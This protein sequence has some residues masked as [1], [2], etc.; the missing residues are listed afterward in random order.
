MRHSRFFF[1]FLLFGGAVFGSCKKEVETQIEIKEVEKQSSWAEVPSLFGL[2]RVIMSSGTDGQNLYLQQPGLFSQFTGRSQRNGLTTTAGRYPADV[3][4]R[5]PIGPS[6]FAYPDTD[7]SLVIAR[8]REQLNNL[9]Y[10]NLRQFDPA[11]T[12]FNTQV[13]SLSKCMAITP[14]NYLLA[15]YD[16]KRADRAFTFVLAAVAPGA[17][18]GPAPVVTTRQVTIP[19]INSSGAYVRNLEAID[20]YFLVNLASNGIY[21][22]KADGTFRQVY[23]PAA[24][25]A[26]YKWGNTVYAP[27]EYNEILTSTDNGEN[28]LKSTGTPLDFTLA[29]YYPVH[30]SLVGVYGSKLYTLRWNGP[31]YTLRTLKNDGLERATI[32]GIEYLRGTVYVA[33]T[34]GLFA[35]PV[36]SFFE[37]KP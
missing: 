26:F 27:I 24:V 4:V 31:R 37:T 25:D 9:F 11:A 10:F 28:W 8:N 22:I 7:T 17:L 29:N 1:G 32:T 2:A 20:D 5:L 3:R 14:T 36:K 6:F 19:R 12:R 30:D 33:T 15:P 23:G 13:F 21:K 18:G 16:N 34:N 35:R